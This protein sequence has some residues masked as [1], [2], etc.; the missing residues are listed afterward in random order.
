MNRGLLVLL[1]LV[2]WTVLSPRAAHAD[3]PPQ[4]PAAT[5]GEAPKDTPPEAP[6]GDGGDTFVDRDGDGL[7][8]G[9]EHRFRGRWRTRATEGGR[10]EAGWCGGHAG[11]GR[12]ERQRGHQ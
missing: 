2:Q 11:Q 3:E 8:D 6:A 4:A 9:Q 10:G 12:G 1:V 7:Q 5:T